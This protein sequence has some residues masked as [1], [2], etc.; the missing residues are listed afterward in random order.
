M[1]NGILAV[2]LNDSIAQ[3]NAGAVGRSKRAH[4]DRDAVL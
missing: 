3:S 2:H 4:F 1:A